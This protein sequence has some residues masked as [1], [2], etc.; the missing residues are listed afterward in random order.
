MSDRARVGA[1]WQRTAFGDARARILGIHADVVL[2]SVG[3]ALSDSGVSPSEITIKVRPVNPTQSVLA[4]LWADIV[5][6]EQ[7]GEGVTV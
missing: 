3:L 6:R 4:S 5:E 2:C 1:S 7:I